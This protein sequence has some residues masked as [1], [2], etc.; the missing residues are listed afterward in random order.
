VFSVSVHFDDAADGD[1]SKNHVTI[2]ENEEEAAAVPT[3]EMGKEQK[4]GLN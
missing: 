4:N 1:G 2:G 3:D